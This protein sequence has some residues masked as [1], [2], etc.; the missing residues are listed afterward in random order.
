VLSNTARALHIC[1]TVSE[2][3]A[4][5]GVDFFWQSPVACD[6]ISMDLNPEPFQVC[7]CGRTFPQSGAFIYHQR[8]CST[9]KKCLVGALALAKEA[10]VDRK[11]R[12]VQ[13]SGYEGATSQVQLST[14]E[15]VSDTNPVNT[16]RIQLYCIK[17]SLYLP[18]SS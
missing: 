1:G 15:A 9:T 5:H 7:T 16:V 4:L 13:N 18:V 6:F 17:V 12:C 14:V 8:S 3:V 10:W 11:R 2:S